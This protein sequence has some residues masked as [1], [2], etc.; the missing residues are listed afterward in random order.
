MKLLDRLAVLGGANLDVIRQVPSMRQRFVAMGLVFV[1]TSSV[2]GLS[3]W[4]A[5]TEGVKVGSVTAVP[6]GLFWAGVVL[7][8]DRFLTMQM[9]SASSKFALLAMALPRLV[10]A[11]VIGAVVSTPLVLRIFQDDIAASVDRQIVATSGQTKEA[12]AK[13]TQQKA[14]TDLQHEV[15]DLR[16]QARGEVKV[17]T[18]A[19]VAKAQSRVDDLTRRRDAQRLIADE[20]QRLYIC[21]LYGKG[22]SGLKDPSKCSPFPGRNGPFPQISADNDAQATL[23]AQLNKELTAAQQALNIAQRNSASTSR[24][25]VEAM[26]A[27]ARQ[28]LP[29]KQQQLRE[30]QTALTALRRQL[31][32]SGLKEKGLLAQLRGLHTL[33]EENSMMRDAHIT[34]MLLFMLIELL[35]VTAK[36]LSSWGP[37]NAYDQILRLTEDEATDKAKIRRIQQQNIEQG[38]ADSIVVTENDMRRREERVSRRSNKEVAAQ[39]QVVMAAALKAW[40]DD[41]SEKLADLQS[42]RATATANG[43]N[44]SL[45]TGKVGRVQKVGSI[46]MA[47]GMPDRDR[48]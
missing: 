25:E 17:A 41:V 9:S 45:R 2:A 7:V 38:K 37:M 31:E 42:G 11:A 15:A 14:V 30:A 34:V 5:L 40:G 33:G 16:A 44:K 32:G 6:I 3:M 10:I 1:T 8:I 23:L 36:V 22:R 26:I 13:S 24:T 46:R 48:L 29:E 27:A 21:E 47:F 35:P 18:S 4:F 39:M 28:A 43:T 19:E 20:A 12:I